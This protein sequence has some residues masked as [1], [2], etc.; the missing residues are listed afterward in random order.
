MDIAETYNKV[1]FDH[2]RRKQW[3]AKMKAYS[4]FSKPPIPTSQANNTR[5]IDLNNTQQLNNSTTIKFTPATNQ[6]R[7]A[8]TKKPMVINVKESLE[9][10]QMDEFDIGY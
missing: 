2:L 1:I 7:K 8:P 4:K 6:G 5:R 10:A 9:K 3:E